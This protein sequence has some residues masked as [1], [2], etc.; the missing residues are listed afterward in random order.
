MFG[1]SQNGRT[2]PSPNRYQLVPGEW[3]GNTKAGA[4]RIKGFVRID[5]W[6]GKAWTFYAD[7]ANQLGEYWSEIQ[8]EEEAQALRKRRMGAEK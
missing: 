7:M 4:V 1:Q 2:E 3:D 6:T 8:T 5:T